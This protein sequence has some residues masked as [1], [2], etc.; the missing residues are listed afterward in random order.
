MTL[1][2]LMLL[3]EVDTGA[4]IMIAHSTGHVL[5]ISVM[6]RRFRCALAV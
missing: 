2:R 4:S 3:F 6:A 5:R 1:A